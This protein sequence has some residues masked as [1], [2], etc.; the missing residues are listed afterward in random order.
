MSFSASAASKPL[1]SPRSFASSFLAARSW[2]TSPEIIYEKNTSDKKRVQ[3]GKT[4]SLESD[5][6][7]CWEAT[8]ISFAFRVSKYATDII[9]PVNN[10]TRTLYDLR[11]PVQG[12]SRALHVCNLQS[13]RH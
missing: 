1:W 8:T 2:S 6:L 12:V 4:R 10:I 3:R 7:V 13:G 5:G 11:A 9:N